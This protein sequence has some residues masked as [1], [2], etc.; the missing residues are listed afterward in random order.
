M[1]L[2]TRVITACLLDTRFA[3]CERVRKSI[4]LAICV[5]HQLRALV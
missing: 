2:V 3:A 5:V 1:P 4:S